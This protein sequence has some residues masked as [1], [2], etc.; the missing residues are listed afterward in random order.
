MQG[1]LIKMRYELAL[2][3]HEKWDGGGYPSGHKGKEIL[4]TARVI[5]IVDVFDAVRT[6]RVNK[7]A[8]SIETCIEILKGE[9]NKHF[10][11]ELVDLFP[12]N[13]DKIIFCKNTIDLK[14]NKPTNGDVFTVIFNNPMS[15]FID[16]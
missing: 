4:L 11:G 3:Q 12:K 10:E 8:F 2:S 16:N 1:Q 15:F 5:A 9:S 6:E 14:F 7:K 13:I